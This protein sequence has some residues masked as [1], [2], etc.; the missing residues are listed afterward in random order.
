MFR[1]LVYLPKFRC[2]LLISI[3]AVL[4]T[5]LLGVAFLLVFMTVVQIWE[6]CRLVV[7]VL[8][9]CLILSFCTMSAMLG[10]AIV[11]M[12]D[13]ITYSSEADMCIMQTVS[14]SLV[15][16]FAAPMVFDLM[17]LGCIVMNTLSRPR[18]A[19]LLLYKAL[20]SDGIIFFA[21]FA[22]L[23]VSEVAL[24]ATLQPNYI[25]MSV[26]FVCPLTNA[27]LSHLLFNIRRF[28]LDSWK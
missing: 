10:I 8:S 13:G 11:Q 16:V 12:W 25:F 18:R 27:S 24:S 3:P 17:A 21:T 7:W 28:D 1:T 4:G 9:G 6:N 26:Y 19:D 23:H 5:I 22:F 20:C 14:K 15:G 2:R